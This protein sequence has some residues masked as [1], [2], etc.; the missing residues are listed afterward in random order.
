MEA[1]KELEDRS[2]QRS[3]LGAETETDLIQG[4][5]E[6]RVW[7]TTPRRQIRFIYRLGAGLV[8]GEDDKCLDK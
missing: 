5:P 6:K 3:C 4:V 8:L 2:L 7:E 1:E